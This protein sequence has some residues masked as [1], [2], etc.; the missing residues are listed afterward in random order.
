MR[1]VQIS[2]KSK[3][4][5]PYQAHQPWQ[6][7][8]LIWGSPPPINIA[9]SEGREVYSPDAP[10]S[11]LLYHIILLSRVGDRPTAT[12][13]QVQFSFFDFCQF[14]KAKYSTKICPS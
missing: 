5:Q 13:L 4:N 10:H 1:G 2:Q 7:N 14:F 12:I 11:I 9:Q 3:V 6:S 8:S